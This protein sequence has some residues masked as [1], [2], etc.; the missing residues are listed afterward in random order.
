MYTFA[1]TLVVV[2]HVYY[3]LVS[4]IL[5]WTNPSVHQKSPKIHREYMSQGGLRTQE[6][7]RSE[8]LYYGIMIQYG[9]ME[10]VVQQDLWLVL[11]QWDPEQV[12]SGQVKLY[13][14]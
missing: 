8:V 3:R 6:Q 12:D 4:D 11:D 9:S 10:V 14:I 5:S 7:N 13:Q 2:V 1:M